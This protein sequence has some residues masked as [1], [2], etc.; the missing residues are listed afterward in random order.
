MFVGPVSYTH[1]DVYKRQING[2]SL[3]TDNN[4]TAGT[5]NTKKILLCFDLSQI[6]RFA[7]VDSAFLFL[8]VN[9]DIR[10]LIE[11]TVE[12]NMITESWSGKLTSWKSRPSVSENKIIMPFSTQTIIKT[13]LTDYVQQWVHEPSTNFGMQIGTNTQIINQSLGFYSSNHPADSL[14][15]KIAVYYSLDYQRN[16]LCNEN[17]H[18]ENPDSI[19]IFD[20][21]YLQP[22]DLKGTDSYLSSANPDSTGAI[23]S[24]LACGADAL[25]NEFRSLLR[26]DLSAIN[27]D[28][29]FIDTAVL[30][31]YPLGGINDIT[32]DFS[33]FPILSPWNES[34]STW[35]NQPPATEIGKTAP[36]KQ[37]DSCTVFDMTNLVTMWALN[38]SI[39]F[40]LMM[41]IN[42][43]SP[44]HQRLYCSSDYPSSLKRP[45]IF[46][47]YR[48]KKVV[49]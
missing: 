19:V 23:S 6:P 3:L 26:F 7:T 49:K 11:E 46:I 28:V 14:H 10:K 47:A 30:Y 41:K 13:N 17:I 4:F 48:Y 24:Q 40:G 20:T 1:L 25:N 34:T 22:D 9:T 37:T 43:I 21:L 29:F 15:P 44:L 39:N 5:M 32:D 42:D 16:C 45:R 8:F 18:P 2:F 35:N 38:P 31:L 36:T 12:I 27:P 33:L